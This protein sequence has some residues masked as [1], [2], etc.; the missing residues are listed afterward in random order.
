MN[1]HIANPVEVDGKLTF[2]LSGLNVS[3]AN[4]IRR[5]IL[6]DIPI[7]VFKTTPYEENKA[8][9]LVN[10][11]RLNN[12]ILKQRLSCIPIHIT[13]L[14]M[15]LKNYIM[16]LNVENITDS[17]IYVT[18]E[19]F[20]VKNITTNQYLS[21]KDT[22]AIFPP[23]DYTGYYIDFVRLRPKITDEIPG[24]KI[25]LSSEFSIGTAKD[26]GSFNVVSTCSYG[27]TPDDAKIDQELRKK[28]QLWKD[29][30]FSE[31]TIK[32][33]SKNWKLLD[34]LRITKPNSFDFIIQTVGVF[35][36]HELFN[37]ACEI[38]I[39]RLIDLDTVLETDELKIERSLNTMENSYDVILEN[40]DYTLGKSIEYI[41]YSKF[42][43]NM[44][45]LSFCGFKKMHP[46]DTESIIR[47]AYHEPT[48]KSVVKQNLKE[49]IID[50]INVFKKINKEFLKIVKN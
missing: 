20:K 32:Y 29:E 46:H 19:H 31:E 26:D 7:V 41:L 33:E 42:F 30:G 28:I 36:N 27:F 16:E 40:E 12:E 9:I 47:I 50:A 11:T 10:T 35:T 37:K 14:E 6:S 17:I 49:C 15:P 38:I 34:G 18:T 43:E 1:P 5:T 4:A 23:N 2:T 39:S 45:T 8:T 24:E 13:D 22:K 25:S 21:E 3:L 44:K 48:E